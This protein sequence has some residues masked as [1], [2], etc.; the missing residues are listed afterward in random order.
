MKKPLIVTRD[1]TERQE[2]IKN[3]TAVLATNKKKIIKIVK[4]LITNK[5]FYTKFI[6]KNNPFGKGNTSIL[7]DKILSNEVFRKKR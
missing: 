4:K 7:I 5:K 6:K 1:V 3:G 2:A